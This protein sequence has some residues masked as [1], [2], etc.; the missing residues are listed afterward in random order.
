MKHEKNGREHGEGK[1]EE[2]K[3]TKTRINQK[4]RR[5]RRKEE[6]RAVSEESVNFYIIS[7]TSDSL[8]VGASPVIRVCVHARTDPLLLIGVLIISPSILNSHVALAGDS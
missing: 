5:T 4:I 6:T 1:R 8:I 3:E 7:N 2:A